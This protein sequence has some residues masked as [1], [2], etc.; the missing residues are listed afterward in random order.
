M[1]VG[2]GEKRNG[3][4][5]SLGL[6]GTA[7]LQLNKTAENARGKVQLGRLPPSLH[8]LLWFWVQMTFTL[9]QLGSLLPQTSTNSLKQWQGLAC[10]LWFSWCVWFDLYLLLWD[11]PDADLFAVVFSHFQ[12][13]LNVLL[14]SLRNIIIRKQVVSLVD[15]K[16]QKYLGFSHLCLLAQ[17]LA[18]RWC[19][20]PCVPAVIT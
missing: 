17:E 10:G 19:F 15:P 3:G 13:F 7:K 1:G 16:G 2:E 9:L 6:L 18:K 8:G 12:C 4:K 5:K 11:C 14:I 20:L